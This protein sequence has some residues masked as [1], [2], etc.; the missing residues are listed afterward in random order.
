MAK[1][2]KQKATKLTSSEKRRITAQKRVATKSI[3]PKVPLI[4]RVAHAKVERIAATIP[5][6]ITMGAEPLAQFDDQGRRI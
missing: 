2:K 5:A 1:A 3:A 4:R 6:K